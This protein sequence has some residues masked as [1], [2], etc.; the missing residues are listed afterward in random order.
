MN[1][2]FFIANLK[3]FKNRSHFWA[4]GPEIGSQMSHGALEPRT[5]SS[6]T[7]VIQRRRRESLKRAVR[8]PNGPVFGANNLN[9]SRPDFAGPVNS[10]V[11][12]VRGVRHVEVPPRAAPLRQVAQGVVARRL[13]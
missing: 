12:L 3:I 11:C 7:R 10:F 2:N 4:D 1:F 13:G 6:R 9:F 8:G 5:G